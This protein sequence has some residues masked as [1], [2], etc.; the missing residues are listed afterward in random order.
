MHLTKFPKPQAP[1]V[2]PVQ[3]L[4]ALPSSNFPPNPIEAGRSVLQIPVQLEQTLP[5]A[6]GTARMSRNANSDH[7]QVQIDR[8]GGFHLTQRAAAPVPV[9]VLLGYDARGAAVWKAFRPCTLCHFFECPAAAREVRC[10]FISP[11][12]PP[13]LTLPPVHSHAQPA[14]RLP[15]PRQKTRYGYE[16]LPRSSNLQ[17]WTYENTGGCQLYR[18]GV[19]HLAPPVDTTRADGEISS[20]EHVVIEGRATLVPPSMSTPATSAPTSIYLYR[21][22]ILAMTA[23]LGYIANTLKR[24]SRS[25][26]KTQDDLLELRKAIEA[27]DSEVASLQRSVEAVKT[28][29]RHQLGGLQG[30]I[31]ALRAKLHDAERELAE[32]QEQTRVLQTALEQRADEAR[33]LMS[34]KMRLEGD[35]KEA[36]SQLATT[37]ADLVDTRAK[38]PAEDRLTAQ[39]VLVLVQALNTEIKETAAFLADSFEFEEKKDEGG[40]TADVEELVEVYERATEILGSDMVEILR[41]ADHHHDT[42]LVRLA[43]Q[44]GMIE[45]ARWMSASWFF[46]DPEDEQLLADV[47]Q[48]LRAAHDQATAGRWRAL[49]HT[50]VQGLIHGEPELGEYFVDAFVNV[51]L[52]AGFK[53][54]AAA[55]HALVSQRF[56]DRI[57]A[58]VRLALGLNKAVGAEVTAC[59]LKALSAAPGVLYDAETMVDIVDGV[60]QP[61]ETVLCTCEL[62]LS[63]SDKIDGTWTKSILLKPKVVLPSGLEELLGETTPT[64]TSK[65]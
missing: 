59:E 31:E 18:L 20:N 22:T 5:V 42:A 32:S 51:L 7:W 52:T 24:S 56:A 39:A 43:F 41:S 33:D 38:L 57:A 6:S 46:E 48:H 44:G 1:V 15:P 40:V 53:S 30:E 60:P 61:D 35:N 65:T 49:T 17:G 29:A 36:L 58:V 3:M 21:A 8:I 10:T 28:D 16:D 2:P 27:R 34:E 55:L 50:H 26:K 11:R 25:S 19:A 62:G 37:T 45:Y 4:P 64:K 14:S 13:S 63:R 47:Y 23:A 12:E 54:S 9:R